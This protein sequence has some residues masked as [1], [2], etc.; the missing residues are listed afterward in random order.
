MPEKTQQLIELAQHGD[1]DAFARVFAPLEH[2]VRDTIAGRL[3]PA[4]RQHIDPEDV[5]QDTFVRA[6][7]S[8]T[9]FE[10]RGEGSFHRWL[11]SIAEH[12]LADVVRYQRRRP[13]LAL[14][15]DV[16]ESAASPSRVM[17]R[18]ERLDRLR[19]SMEDLSPDHRRVLELSRLEGLSIKEIARRLERSEDAVKSLLLRATKALRTS[20]GETESLRLGDARFNGKETQDES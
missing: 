8:V 12:V 18:K 11:E 13:T 10:W 6:L 19:T 20:F 14:A 16:R 2:S 5:L 1:Q 7:H 3:S 9:R 15:D 17:K 4:V